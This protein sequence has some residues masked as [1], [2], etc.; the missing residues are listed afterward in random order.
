MRHPTAI[1]CLALAAPTLLSCDRQDTTADIDPKLGLDCFQIHRT[2]LPPGTQYEGIDEV[3]ADK[4]VIKVM[5]GAELQTVECG[6]GPDGSL[7][8]TR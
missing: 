5:T 1:I 4:L 2:A 7:K 6:M 3:A 8:E